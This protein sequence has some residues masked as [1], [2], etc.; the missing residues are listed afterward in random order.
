MKYFVNDKSYLLNLFKHFYLNYKNY[1]QTQIPICNDD[2][3]LNG[4]LHNF[5]FL[6]FFISVILTDLLLFQSNVITRHCSGIFTD[7]V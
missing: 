5:L 7:S 6:I 3:F 4:L 2:T 1:L